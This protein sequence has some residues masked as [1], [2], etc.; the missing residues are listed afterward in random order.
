M[1][2]QIFYISF[3]VLAN[4]Y[5]RSSPEP[6]TKLKITSTDSSEKYMIVT[7]DHRASKAAKK[8]LNF[9]GNAIDAAIAAQNV[10]SVV[11]P[12]SSGLGGGGFLLFY[13]N[14]KK[15]II[16][17][18]GRETAPSSANPEMFLD[19]N[20]D[21]LP[22]L[23]AVS[24]PKSVGVPG[25]YNMLADAHKNHGKIEWKKLFHDA[26]DYSNGFEVSF[27]LN[28]LISWAPHIKKNKFVLDT[29]YKQNLP[30]KPGSIVQN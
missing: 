27:R 15:Q 17:Y 3:G 22:F 23:D 29:Y 1:I 30:K 7:A 20:G 2:V 25:L 4:E 6:A 12:Q 13:D 11:E 18:D 28:K 5:K 9:G 21:K 16:A 10:L 19:S 8:I 24:H 26:I 14:V